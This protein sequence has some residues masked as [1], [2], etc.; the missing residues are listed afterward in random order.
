MSK[1]GSN[2]E[3]GFTSE[4]LDEFKTRFGELEDRFEQA[5]HTNLD[6]VELPSAEHPDQIAEREAAE[7]KSQE[8]EPGEFL[9][10][11]EVKPEFDAAANN[12][13]AKDMQA[14]Q[15]GSEMV[16]SDS[17]EHNMRPPPEISSE[18]DRE[19]HY[20]QMNDDNYQSRISM[21]DSYYADLE[22]RM[23]DYALEQ[24]AAGQ[25]AGQDQD[26]GQGYSP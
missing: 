7:A 5:V 24:E 4:T 1:N 18:Q 15:R 8:K 17:P 26:D 16:G 12:E 20:E 22:A 21:T 14:E 13:F 10:D 6:R 11:H 9:P 19:T 25:Q 3:E 2:K 23:E